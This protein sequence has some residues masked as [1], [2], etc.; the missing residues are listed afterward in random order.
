MIKR[1]RLHGKSVKIHKQNCILKYK[2]V[3][4]LLNASIVVLQWVFLGLEAKNQSLKQDTEACLL[5]Y[6]LLQQILKLM[7]EFI[8]PIIFGQIFIESFVIPFS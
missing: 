4:N 1:E 3:P 7:L 5:L 8:L 6:L 2:K